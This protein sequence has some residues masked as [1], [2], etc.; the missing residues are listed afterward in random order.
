MGK[1]LGSPVGQPPGI[2]VGIVVGIPEGIA[3]P[4][5]SAVG[6]VAGIPD[7]TASPEGSAQ[8][9]APT[10]PAERDAPGRCGPGGVGVEG[11]ALLTIAGAP[12]AAAVA[13]TAVAGGAWAVESELDVLHAAAATT[14]S[15]VNIR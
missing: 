7:G 14:A 8:G 13:P 5:G 6:M 3:S 12:L 9:S 1:L 4:E 10:P 2:A 11:E 15:A